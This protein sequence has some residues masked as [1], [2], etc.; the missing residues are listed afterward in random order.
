VSTPRQAWD[1]DVYLSQFYSRLEATERHTLSF[2]HRLLATRPPAGRALDFGCGP[3]LHH[4]IALANHADE[5]HVADLMPDNLRSIRR[6]LRNAPGA[7]DWSPLTHEV[8]R[9]E[10][11]PDTGRSV[12][13]R[14][15]LTR[16]RLTRAM[17]GDAR[18]RDPLGPDARA[19]YDVVTSFFCADSSTACLAEWQRY[20]RNI[21]S[22]VAPSGCLVLG[23]LR[24]CRAWRLG[25]ASLPSPCIDERH[26]EFVLDAAGFAPSDRILEVADVPD[27]AGNGFSSILLACARAPAL[28]RCTRR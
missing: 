20:T 25:G 28:Q 10:H 7:F 8:L 12:Y 23:A 22:L 26:L 14:E 9:L 2:L 5:V 11:A 15:Q 1:A 13:E 27:Q 3:T 18:R 6:W 21:A 24:R 19:S 17:P 4:A 16:R